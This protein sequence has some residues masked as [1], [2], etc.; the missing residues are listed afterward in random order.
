MN[1]KLY[2]DMILEDGTIINNALIFEMSEIINQLTV[3]NDENRIRT[4]FNSY[5]D[6]KTG[7][8]VNSSELIDFQTST[9]SGQVHPAKVK[10][11]RIHD[12]SGKYLNTYSSSLGSHFTAEEAFYPNLNKRVC[13]GLCVGHSNHKESI[14]F[15]D[16]EGVLIHIK[17]NI[18]IIEKDNGTKEMFRLEDVRYIKVLDSC[19]K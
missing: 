14:D 5:R 2:V 13:V 7:D 16:C 8:M 19:D 1:N 4:K 15:S 12:S 11:Y 3:I 9:I 10:K 6:K 18:F 17:C